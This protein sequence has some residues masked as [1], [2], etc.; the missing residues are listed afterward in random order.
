MP[1]T[2]AF[3]AISRPAPDPGYVWGIRQNQSAFKSP[4]AGTSQILELPGSRWFFRA[5]WSD[6]TPSDAALMRVFLSQLRG[7]AN[8]FTAF[9]WGRYSPRGVASGSP[10]VNGAGQTGTSLAVGSAPASVTNWL[11]PDDYI[12][13]GGYLHQVTATVLTSGG[14]FATIPI[15]PPLRVS[16][17]NAA[18][19]T[20]VR[21]TAKFQ[22]VTNAPSYSYEPDRGG[23][24]S[25]FDI[26][27]VE[28]LS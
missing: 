2:Y 12:G 21:P 26:E 4:L 19:V 27:A 9:H 11:M 22:L 28:V 6:L 15:E 3:P 25:T 1:T 23:A 17:T 13:V 8:Y 7:G 10:T 20:I 16:P 5:R 18:A 14:G 24:S